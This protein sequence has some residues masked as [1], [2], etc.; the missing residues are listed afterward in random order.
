MPKCNVRNMTTL[1]IEIGDD[2]TRLAAEK[3]R[4]ANLTVSEWIARRIA[5]KSRVRA[6]GVR[7]AMGYPTGW[8]E[9]TAG[10]LADV[11]DFRE[12]GDPRPAPIAPLDL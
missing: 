7:D 12:P 8:F 2:D 1:T 6:S 10:S 4:R 5:G 11:E 9:R 3:A